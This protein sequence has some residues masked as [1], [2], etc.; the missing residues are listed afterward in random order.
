MVDIYRIP[1]S[2]IVL[3]RELYEADSD[4]GAGTT[5][6]QVSFTAAA[7][8]RGRAPQILHVQKGTQIPR[9]LVLSLAWWCLYCLVLFIFLVFIHIGAFPSCMFKNFGKIAKSEISIICIIYC[10]P[11]TYI[12]FYIAIYSLTR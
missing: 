3:Y 9:C 8:L 2:Q 1:R 7:P 6:S 5:G 12:N 10:F 11:K 4:G